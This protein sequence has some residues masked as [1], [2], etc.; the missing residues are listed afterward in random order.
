M[1]G[2]ARINV[3]NS[4]ALPVRTSLILLVAIPALVASVACGGDDDDEGGGEGRVTRLGDQPVNDHGT[5]D[6]TGG[7][8]LEINAG[9]FYFEPTFV[10]GTPGQKLRLRIENR[11]EV[12]HNF[13]LAG[14]LDEDVRAGEALEAELTFPE[15][16]VVLFLCK[17][18][19]GQGMVGELLSGDAQPTAVAAP[20]TAA[21]PGAVGADPYN[22]Y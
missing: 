17:Y 6:V 11:G 22:P 3:S 5:R 14:G 15:G 16:G 4:G 21:T 20:S 9:D 18:H 8:D 12:I 2:R 1:R 7:A 19:Q 13:S 10:R